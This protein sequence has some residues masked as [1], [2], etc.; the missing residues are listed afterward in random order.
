MKSHPIVE[1]SLPKV[2]LPA[3][4]L[5]SVYIAISPVYDFRFWAFFSAYLVPINTSLVLTFSADN[6]W[7]I[8]SILAY[9]P[10]SLESSANEEVTDMVLFA[11]ESR[12][13]SRN[14][15][16]KPK[17]KVPEGTFPSAEASVVFDINYGD[18]QPEL[19]RKFVQLIK[20]HALL[21][22]EPMLID[23][24]REPVLHILKTKTL[25]I[26]HSLDKLEITNRTENPR[27]SS[28][29][30]NPQPASKSKNT[31]HTNEAKN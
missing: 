18:V 22:V 14:T 23:G 29:S 31:G 27:P 4:A 3:T 20:G 13:N 12:H 9:K 17:P 21:H 25:G 6:K 5:A 11:P 30:K 24:K 16:P 1:K 2:N 15:T 10:V 26:S 7:A 8:L 28:K 19:E